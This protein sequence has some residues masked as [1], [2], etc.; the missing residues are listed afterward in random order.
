MKDKQGNKLTMKEYFKRWG[1][2]INKVTPIQKVNIQLSGTKIMLFGLVAGLIVSLINYK[3]LWWVALIL[4]GGIFNTF[5][6]LITQIQQKNAFQNLEDNSVSL[7]TL[8]K[9]D[10]L[11]ENEKEKE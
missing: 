10:K 4:I 6:Q 5:I 9:L 8:N 11:F 3:N 7:D 1:E 2:G